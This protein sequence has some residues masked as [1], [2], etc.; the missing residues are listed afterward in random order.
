MSLS[1]FFKLLGAPLVNSRWSWGGVR[2]DGAVFLRV[3]QDNVKLI[4]GVQYVRV[5][6]HE[7]FKDHSDDRGYQERLKQLALVKNGNRCYLVMCR[8]VDESAKVRK[9]KGY[10]KD[11]VFI[12]G[13][14]IEIDGDSWIE[15][16][17]RVP[18]RSLD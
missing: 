4:N 9:I 11:D 5:T 12:G 17:K 2:E 7:R 1:G 18:A 3:W 15:S 10:I 16:V 6:H 8:A 13:G 14:I